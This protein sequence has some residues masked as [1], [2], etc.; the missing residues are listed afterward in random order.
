[1]VV[2]FRRRGNSIRPVHRI[3]HVVDQQL[4]L[5]LNVQQVFDL[6]NSID[7]PTVAV[8]NAVETGCTING[9][10]LNVE[11]YATTAGALANIYIAVVKNP[12]NNLTF[13][14]AN[15]VGADDNK[16][17]VIHQEMKMLEQSVNGNPRTL[18]NGVI[19]IPKGYRRM[20]INDTIKILI[21][22]PGVNCS[23]CFQCHYKEFR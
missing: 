22:A 13:P 23:V 2:V 12:G 18:F 21:F 4:G 11:G 14:N 6:A 7:A 10:Y 19:V 5:V 1:M 8:T 17:F 3:K 16:R 15:A 20:A 9:I